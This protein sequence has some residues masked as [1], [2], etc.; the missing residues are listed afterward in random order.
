M[1]RFA[2]VLL[3]TVAGTTVAKA[4]PIRSRRFQAHNADDARRWQQ[5]SRSKLFALMMGGQKPDVVPLDPRVQPA[6]AGPGGS[7][8]EEV[9]LQ[10]LPDRRVRAW[11]VR[12]A[13]PQGKVGAVLALHGHGG[14]GEQVVRGQ[15]LYW[16][17]KHLAQM[18]FAVIAPDIGSHKLQ[19]NSWSLMGERTWDALRCVDYLVTLP[20]VDPARLAVAGL[21]LG[22]ETA[23][24]VAALDGRLK[25]VCSSG[26][27][28]TVANMKTGHCPCWNFKGLEE[29]FDFAD[30]FACI[31]P[32]ALI[33]EI[34]QKER[35]PGG[36][37]VDIA[38]KAFAD[39]LPVYR[40]LGA[41]KQALLDIHPD[42]H[43]FHGPVF[44]KVLDQA[45]GTPKP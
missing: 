13:K 8:L 24:Y 14:S 12:P 25:A 19:H 2:L 5:E 15:G 38:Q 10:T 17:G 40:V 20:E 32:R 29:H 7:I 22:G 21:S 3:F 43:V 45:L 4:E 44:W 39:I 1:K 6:G 23:M 11:V 31:A 26:W 35:A 28:T 16:Y 30:I 36:F 18:G 37:P 9:T 33:C 42:G 27:L 41:E 34:G